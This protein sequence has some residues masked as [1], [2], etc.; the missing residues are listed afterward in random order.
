MPSYFLASSLT[1]GGGELARVFVRNQPFQQ[2]KII[3]MVF[4]CIKNISPYKTTKAILMALM[5]N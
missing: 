1:L 3:K 4:A 5:P 2:S